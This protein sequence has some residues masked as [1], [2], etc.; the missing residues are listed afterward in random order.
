MKESTKDLLCLCLSGAGIT[1]V[2]LWPSFFT[3][4]TSLSYYKNPNTRVN[5]IYATYFFFLV[6]KLLGSVLYPYMFFVFGTTLMYTFMVISEIF[7]SIY[8]YMYVSFI[9]ISFVNL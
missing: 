8:S 6:G 3:Y 7:M 4:Y 2:N 9:A 1:F 5:L